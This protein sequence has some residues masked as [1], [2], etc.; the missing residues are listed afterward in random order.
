MSYKSIVQQNLK[1]LSTFFS[2][3]FRQ[4][5]KDNFLNSASGLVYS[6]LLAIVPAATFLF[7]FFNA[8]GVMEPLVSFLS[9]W[10][11]ELAGEEAG[12]QLMILLTQ[13]T[14]NATSL[15]VVGLI[16]F[17]ITMV[18]L[19]N[20]VWIVINRIYRSSRSRN[21]LKRFAGYISF[22]IV[23]T[24]LL[25]AYVSAQSIL[26]SWY[27]NLIG[28]TLGRWSVAVEA[29]A[30]SFIVALVIFLLIYLVPN[31][32][33]RFDSAIL[34]SIAGLLVINIFS[35]LTSLLTSM[36]SRF[37]VIYGSFAAIFLFLFFCYVFWATVFFSVELA[38]VHQF[39][40]DVSSFRGL[41]QS[42]A[43]QLSE[44][45]NIMMLIGSNFREGK[46]ATSTKELLDR[47]AIPY[48][49]L[50]GFLG[51]LTQLEFITPTN[52][53]QTS[54]IPKQ[55]LDTLRLQD[56]VKGLYGM[57]TIDEVEHDTAG[58]AVAEQVQDRG[59]AAL[60]NLTIEQ[61]LQRI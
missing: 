10:F 3:V 5:M 52:S 17:L 8:F 20:K 16:S 7:T 48:N 43:L 61:L 22:L 11:T 29:I 1:R 19:I 56:L 38:Y 26:T 57:E 13:Y 39:R 34:G 6:T 36:A 42:P 32:R 40:P 21:A 35:K 24:L 12:G 46:G 44:G 18:L 49:R 9:Q 27:L 14:R 41:P 23:A 58:E 60:G 25:A 30:P 28:V 37:S 47:L 4:A 31:T 51:L 15:G 55:P 2:A 54:Y 59:V 53:S 50:Q 33:V 45:T